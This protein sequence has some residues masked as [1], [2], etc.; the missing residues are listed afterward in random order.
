MK[1]IPSAGPW[2]TNLEIKSVTDAISKGW[3]ENWSKDILKFEKSFSKYINIKHSL[4]TS[5]CTGA[6]HIILKAMGIKKGDEIIVPEVS[7]IATVSCIYYLGAK[8]VY[9]DIEKDTWCLDP[10]DVKRKITSKTKAI[11]PV[12]MYGHP[13]DMTQINKIAKNYGIWV[14]ED[15]APGIGSK[16][17]DKLTGSFGDASAFSFQGAKPIVTG[18]GGMICTNNSNL[19]DKIYFYWDHGRDKKKILYNSEIG[20][21]YK[22]SNIQ[23]ALGYAQLQR[24]NQIISKRRKIFSWY[25]K[26]LGKNDKIFMNIER[27]NYFN[28]FYVP[29]II[30]K[31]ANKKFRDDFSSLLNKKGINNRPFFRPISKMLKGCKKADTPVADQISDCGINLPC[32]TKL[33]KEQIKYVSSQINELLNE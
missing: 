19:F 17:N 3:Y 9:C 12:H 26:Y 1:N 2:I 4:T 29:S 8:P 22:M 27:K 11:I 6:L 31:N 28:N 23:A 25:H 30:I 21:K 32:A 13:A 20:F 10:N 5:S 16:I 7:W 18:E 15:A 24:I 14:V 33:T